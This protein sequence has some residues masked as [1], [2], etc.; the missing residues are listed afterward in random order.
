MAAESKVTGW[1]LAVHDLEVLWLATEEQAARV[2]DHWLSEMHDLQSLRQVL[3]GAG[4][5]ATG[6]HDLLG[7]ARLAHKEVLLCRVFAWLLQVDG[8]HGIGDAFLRRLLNDWMP[9][10]GEPKFGDLTMTSVVTEEAHDRTRADVIVRGPNWTVVIEAKVGAGEQNQ[11]GRRLEEGW[12]KEAPEFIFL[13]R[14]GTR[15]MQSGSEAWHP[16]SWRQVTKHLGEALATSGD[17][18]LDHRGRPAA[19][20]FL[21]TLEAYY[22]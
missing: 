6:P 14:G 18:T 11:Q 20:E 12:Q 1:G 5:W 2:P 22:S 10:E 17:T 13:T 7:V 4:L 3:R 9:A 19:C 15:R 21:R 8:S 16:Y